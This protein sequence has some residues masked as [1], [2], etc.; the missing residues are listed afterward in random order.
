MS[1]LCKGFRNRRR[2]RLHVGKE[3]KWNADTS[4]ARRFSQII[5]ISSVL[6]A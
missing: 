4:D 3:W 2:E 1:V 6:S 5:L